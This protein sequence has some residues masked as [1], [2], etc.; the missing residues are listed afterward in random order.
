MLTMKTSY[1]CHV[2]WLK[3]K[4]VSRDSLQ[5]NLLKCRETVEISP[6]KISD[7]LKI[8]I[9]FLVF[10]LSYLSQ[11]MADLNKFGLKI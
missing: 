9:S 8:E 10:K 1:I 11:F 3:L 6:P 7:I 2:L 4:C 5:G